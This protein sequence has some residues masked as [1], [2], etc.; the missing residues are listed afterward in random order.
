[1]QDNIISALKNIVGQENVLTTK[2]ELTPY[3]HAEFPIKRRIPAVIRPGSTAEVQQ[4]VKLAS[5][6]ALSLY[7]ISTGKNWGY[8]SANPVRDDNLILDLS[9]MNRIL[10]VNT[11]LA[12]AVVQPGVTQQNFYDYLE[13]NQTGLMMDPT[14]SGP[15]CSILGNS[16][17]RGYGITPHGDHFSFVCGLEVV[18]TDGEVLHTGFGHFENSKVD[19][20]FKW[21]VGPYLDGLFTQSNFGIVTAMG[22]WLMPKP[23]CI[24]ACYFSCE[25]EEDIYPLI[26]ALRWLL[27]NNVIRSSINLAHRN[28]VLTML[29]QYPWEQMKGKTPLDPQLALHLAAERK[30]GAWNGVCGIY[31]TKGEAKEAKKVVRK[32]LRG[33]VSRINFVSGTL[34]RFMEKYPGPLSLVTGMNVRELVKVIKPSFG[35]LSGKPSEVSLASPYWRSR[36]KPPQSN[37]NPVA[38]N[39]GLYWFAPVVPMV[40]GHAR[41]FIN[42][43]QTTLTRHGFEPCIMFSTVTE[44]CFDCNL[45]ILYDKEDPEQTRKAGECYEDV[46]GACMR[47]GYIPY[48]VGIQSMEQL[49]SKDDPFWKTVQRI[50][51]ALDPREILSPGRYCR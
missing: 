31:G 34:L 1:M 26:D 7:P 6:H 19:R 47:A 21:G 48:R 25:R 4:V 30:V 37:I 16:L 17:E 43:V 28:R 50:K 15:S 3:T 36:K 10:E 14:G 45:P 5:D 33:K 22:V 41:E 49:V 11:E 23:E 32:V 35:I 9:R 42:I 51:S 13:N 44:R 27:Q 24:E 18:L 38:D 29:M 2:A 20:V 8:G 12:Y 40:Q 39:C 46:F